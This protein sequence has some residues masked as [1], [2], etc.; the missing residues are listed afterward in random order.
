MAVSKKVVSYLKKNKVTYKTLKHEVA[1]TAQEIAAAQHVSGKV[2]AKS[3]LIKT[4]KKDKNFILAVLPAT[5]LIDFNKLKKLAKVKK[6][7]LA[8]EEDMSKLFPD[9]EAGAMAPL[10]PLY[11]IPIYI[12]KTLGLG[13]DIIFNAGTHTDMI[14]IRY[15]DFD[16]LNKPTTGIFGKLS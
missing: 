11:N 6:L 16:K 3:V 12:D 2:V 9:V 13:Q 14:K 7:T 1:Y 10:G 4:D 8:K 5:H 15:R